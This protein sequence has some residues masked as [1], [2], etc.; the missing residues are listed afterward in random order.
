MGHNELVNCMK[1]NLIVDLLYYKGRKKKKRFS[2][3][4]PE[5]FLH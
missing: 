1:R 2:K 3:V 5:N 4:S